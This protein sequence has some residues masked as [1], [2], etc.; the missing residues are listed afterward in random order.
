MDLPCGLHMGFHA[1]S[2]DIFC[3]DGSDGISGA[4][5]SHI[6]QVGHSWSFQKVFGS[7][8]LGAGGR[9]EQLVLLG[10]GALDQKAAGLRWKLSLLEESFANMHHG[11]TLSWTCV[12][13]FGAF[14]AQILRGRRGNGNVWLFARHYAFTWLGCSF[15]KCSSSRR[16]HVL[17]FCSKFVWF[18]HFPAIVF[19]ADASELWHSSLHLSACDFDFC[20]L[21]PHPFNFLD[22]LCDRN[23]PRHSSLLP[24]DGESCHELF[25]AQSRSG[26]RSSKR[27]RGAQHSCEF[28]AT[29][30]AVKRGSQR[31]WFKGR[32]LVVA[33]TR[34]YF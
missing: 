10:L 25:P 11:S 13:F 2:E 31:V 7:L 21:Q 19:Y 32:K 26:R 3:C 24:S 17:F 6:G 15:A 20:G 30:G 4:T 8:L 34:Y 14:L 28:H 29:R 22:E 16:S 27:A 23:P 5:N 1:S 33:S 18:L 9:G 12:H